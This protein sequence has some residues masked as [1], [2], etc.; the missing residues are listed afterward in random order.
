MKKTNIAIALS[1]V[2]AVCA[3][4]ANA[5]V[6]I[7]DNNGGGNNKNGTVESAPTAAN[8]GNP[9][10]WGPSLGF[11]G[12]TVTGGY[13]TAL[14]LWNTDFTKSDITYS[15]VDQDFGNHGGLGVCSYNTNCS[16][17]D[18]SF[19]SNVGGETLK[20]EVL[21]FDFA[22]AVTLE[23]IWFNGGHQENVGAGAKFNIY[24]STDGNAY[25]SIFSDKM[26]VAPT[27]GEYITTGLTNSYTRYAVAA[28]GLGSWESYVEAIQV[29]EP[30][31]LALLGLGLAGLG[32][33]RRR[34]A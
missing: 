1:A 31:T 24:T 28:S 14:S 26:Q 6:I 20:D 15:N 30:G 4:S 29:P 32:A 18:D 2:L 33:A 13:T 10:S 27:N 16:G 11:T 7:F 9:N 3:A 12:F 22:S 23:K 21:F 17:D 25:T 19:Q 8:T 5:T 34:K